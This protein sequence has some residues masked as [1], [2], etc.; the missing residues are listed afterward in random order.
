MHPEIA[1]FCASHGLPPALA[2]ELSTLVTRLS[3]GSVAPAMLSGRPLAS[4]D[5]PSGESG[6]P[7]RYT[8]VGLLGVGGMGEVLRVLDRELGRTCAFKSIKPELMRKPSVVARFVE[9]AQIGAQLQHPNI[10]PVYDGGRTPDGR[11]WFTMK[12]VRGRTFG[13]LIAEAHGGPWTEAVL[14]RLCEV[15]AGVCDA[16]GYAHGRGVVHRDLKPENVKVGTHGEVYVLD[17]GLAKVV[18]SPDLALTDEEPEVATG[19]SADAAQKTRMGGVMGT[20]SYM[21]PEQARGEVD[22]LGARSDVY[23]L[24]AI[25]YEVLSGRPPYEGQDGRAVLQQVLSGPPEPPGRRSKAPVRQTFRFDLDDEEEEDVG[26]GS[27]SGPALPEE[28]LRLCL[29][30][31]SREP[32]DRPADGA[33]VGAAL[34]GWLDGSGKRARALEVVGR[35][36]ATVGEAAA[37]RERAAALR[38]SGAAALSGVQAWASE[39]EKAAGWAQEDEADRLER[40]AELLDA[41]REALLQASLTH[42]PDLPEGHAALAAL[43]EARHAAAEA[44]RDEAGAARAEA[45]LREHGEALP[46][47]HAVRRH[48]AA[49]LKGDG[50]LTLETD[51]PGAEVHLSRYELR[52]RRLVE[53]PVCVLGRTPLRGVSLPQG[54]YMCRLTHPDRAPVRYPVFLGRG[55]HWDGVAPGEPAPRPVRL[56]WPGELGPEDC[57][58]PA[59]WFWSG[60]DPEANNSLPRRRLWCEALVVRRVPVINRQYIAFLDDL[61]AAGREDEAL[62]HAPRERGGTA[63]ELGSLIY[64]FAAGRFALRP[65]A[66]GD[67]WAP[68]W[69]ACMVDWHGACAYAAWEE[70]RTGQG[71]RLPGELEWEKASRGVDGRRFPWGDRFDP[72]WACTRDSNAGRGLPRDVD[73]FPVDES[74]YGARGMAGNMLDWCADAWRPEGPPLAGAHSVAPPVGGGT[75]EAERGS[76]RVYRGGSWASPAIYARVASRNS[77]DAADRYGNLSFRLLRTYR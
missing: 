48:T 14:H 44:A 67:V 53:V 62:R 73:T 35:A 30:C 4:S 31:L 21:P 28:L 34:R 9:E 55:E 42:A 3:A 27:E 46:E 74:V 1:S 16:V 20:A 64:G 33:A 76:Y 58:V 60:G 43:V 29:G 70:A 66:D 5:L 77:G 57:L 39:D 47:D 23:A 11:P 69:P 15:L 61:V 2:A 59:G 36:E 50:A 6:L 52:N 54:S 13:E 18:G 37:L 38:A 32:G 8:S 65:D 17:W 22:R 10:P 19:R 25:L 12:E 68:D 49:Y 72:S 7:A 40:V 51:P 63:G 26:A 41:S 24:G 75:Q 45:R 71:W 56:P